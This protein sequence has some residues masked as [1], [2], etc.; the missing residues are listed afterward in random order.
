MNNSV[1][2]TTSFALNELLYGF[3]INDNLSLLKDL[4]T[5]DYNR[6]RQIKR[7]TADEAIAF[8]NAVSKI[9]Y[10]KKHTALH[11]KEGSY[12]Y[13]KLH[14]GYKVPG[15]TNRKLSQQHAG[16]F[17]ILEKVGN[18]AYRLELPPTM[19]IHPVVSIA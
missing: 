1:N 6:L 8:T 11:L 5:K 9:R 2:F 10:N 3:K 16:P 15:L 18:L 4:P 12:A 14:H 13:L 19:R 7:D 17:K